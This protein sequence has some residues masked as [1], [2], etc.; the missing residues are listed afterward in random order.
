M[1][2]RQYPWKRLW[3]P[4]G[5]TVFRDGGFV[6]VPD[7][8]DPAFFNAK[9]ARLEDLSQRC[10]ILLGQP[11]LGKSTELKRYVADLEKR[12]EA[13][14]DEVLFR[15]LNVYGTDQR[16][17]VDIFE[18]SEFQAW[19]RGEHALF[20]C[21]DS[22]DEAQLQIKPVINLLADQLGRYPLDRLYLRLACRSAEWPTSLGETLKNLWT[23]RTPT[24]DTAAYAVYGLVPLSPTDVTVAATQ[25]GLDANGFLEAVTESHAESFAE[26]PLTLEFLLDAFRKTGSLPRKRLCLFEQGCRK[27]CSEWNPSRRNSGHVGNYTSDQRLA[28][29][30][31]LAALSLLTNRNVFLLDE[32][33]GL[34]PPGTLTIRDLTGGKEVVSSEDVLGITEAAVQET[35]Q[36]AL[37]TAESDGSITWAH[38]SYAEALAACHLVNLDLALP[39][40][41][42]LLTHP[43]TKAVVP[44]L[45]EVAAFVAEE[46]EQF[47]DRILET[48]D[49]SILLRMDLSLVGDQIRSRLVERILQ[50]LDDQKIRSIDRTG[51]QYLA[52]PGLPEQLRPYIQT[53]G[54]YWRAD[55]FAFEVAGA[56]HLREL[57]QDL[58]QVASDP[59]EEPRRRVPAVRAIATH[60]DPMPLVELKSILRGL[61]LTEDADCWIRASVLDVLWPKYLSAQELFS[62]RTDCG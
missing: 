48:D 40:L 17:V 26:R 20:L 31:R 54:K 42:S 53:G 21:L 50:L 29:A 56:C 11:G 52:H 36:T 38:Q 27:L 4:E 33:L 45:R 9:L 46:R 10:L 25:S 62:C 7:K 43:T 1:T 16:L 14:K 55:R 35:L 23:N 34:Q 24:E 61:T 51:F 58:L 19:K 41:H 60:G 57:Q 6:Y 15:D 39:K 49:P 18:R 59:E 13:E 44:Q 8:Q 5:E 12:L 37:F 47:R 2:Q 32:P 22:L 28:V 3:A 30:G